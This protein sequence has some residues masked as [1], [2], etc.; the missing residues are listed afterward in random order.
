M[1]IWLGGA[2]LALC[3]ITLLL[4]MTLIHMVLPSSLAA[5]LGLTLIHIDDD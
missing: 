5:I 1:R 3:L 2:F 4:R